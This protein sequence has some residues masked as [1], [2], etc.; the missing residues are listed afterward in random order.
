[1]PTPPIGA[2]VCMLGPNARQLG[3]ELLKPHS[4]GW[5]T[6]RLGWVDPGQEADGKWRW[7]SRMSALEALDSLDPRIKS[8]FRFMRRCA[9]D[10]RRCACR[11]ISTASS[12]RSSLAHSV[13][14]AATR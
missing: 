5:F 3:E 13:G 4:M 14:E 6:D 1:M 9:D 7:M 10:Y 12:I 8:D 11:S 2:F